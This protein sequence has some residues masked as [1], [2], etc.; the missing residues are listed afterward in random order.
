MFLLQEKSVQHSL[1]DVA[2]RF[3]RRVISLARHM[4]FAARFDRMRCSFI[5]DDDE[6]LDDEDGSE[7]EGNDD[8]GSDEISL[9]D[10]LPHHLF[11]PPH[12]QHRHEEKENKKGPIL[13]I[14]PHES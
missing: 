10:V 11:L 5:V 4:L 3:N 2:K 14:P 9:R 7:D 8:S 1:P 6:P 13:S 12:R